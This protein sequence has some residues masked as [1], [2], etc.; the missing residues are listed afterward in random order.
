MQY[1]NKY[2]LLHKAQLKTTKNAKQDKG[3]TDLLVRI[4]NAMDDD[5]V[6]Q[7]KDGKTD[8]EV[9]LGQLVDSFI[10]TLRSGTNSR[11]AKCYQADMTDGNG[12]WEIKVSAN[13]YNLAT[14][15]PKPMRTIFITSTGAYTITKKQLEEIF[16]DHYSFQDYVKE[17]SKGFRLKPAIAE[18]GKPCAWLNKVLGF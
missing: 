2:A 4:A 17:D 15:L 9:N 18:I 7:C 11:W 13:C 12:A 10:N 16:D 6:L 1:L 8:D 14:A 5:M 3:V